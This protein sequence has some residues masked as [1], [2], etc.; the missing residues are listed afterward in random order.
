MVKRKTAYLVTA[1]LLF[2]S[3]VALTSSQALA[4]S[5]K[6]IASASDLPAIVIE[7]PAKPSVLATDGGPAFDRIR[8]QVEAYA[9]N[10]LDT[11]DVRDVA[12]RKE[13]LS[14]LQQVAL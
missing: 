3:G 6:V 14:L 9:K 5:K 11:Y 8:D 2:S 1:A 10:V 4:Q 7:L 13:L 12:T